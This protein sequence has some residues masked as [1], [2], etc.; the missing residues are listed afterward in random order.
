LKSFDLEILTGVM[1]GEY[2]LGTKDLHSK[3]CYMIYG[4]LQPHEIDRLV[5]PGEGH[6]EILCAV[7]GPLLVHTHAGTSTLSRGCAVHL[8]ENE[9]FFISNPSDERVRYIAAGAPKPA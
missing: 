4:I 7:D 8:K 3:V 6:E 5:K 2:V 1:G 9:S